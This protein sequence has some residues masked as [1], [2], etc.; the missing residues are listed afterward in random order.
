MTL[1]FDL[2]DIFASRPSLLVVASSTLRLALKIYYPTLAIN[3]D[4]AVITRP[5]SL[6]Q[7]TFETLSEHLRQSFSTG[8][9]LRWTTGQNTLIADPSSV[10]ALTLDIDI[11]QLAV[12]VDSVSLA[13]VTAFMQAM[14]EF[15]DRPCANA[16][17]PWQ[18]LS[19][20]LRQNSLSKT[21]R[22]QSSEQSG[23]QPPA[24]P[25]GAV[26][27]EVDPA[28][29]ERQAQVILNTQL[30]AIEGV[31]SQGLGDFDEIERYLEKV[32]DVSQV[33]VDDPSASRL[34][35]NRRFEQLPEWLRQASSGERLDYSRHVAALAVS[36]SRSKGKSFNDDLPPILKYA[37][38]VLQ[39]SLRED[40]PEAALTLDD[41]TVEIAKVVASAIPSGGQIIT[42]GSVEN[43]RMSVAAFALENL[44]SAPNGTLTL[45]VR[46]GGP[47]PDWLTPDYLKQLVFRVDIG[48]A[49][50]DLVRHYL[51]TD[52]VEVARR[53]AL[54]ADQL[55]IQLPL[56]ALEQKIRG[57]GNLTLA[58]YQHVCTVLGSPAAKG[59][60]SSSA[61]WPLAFVAS[62]GAPAD[63]VTNMFV[64]GAPDPEIGPFVLYRP[65]ASVP[66][67]EFTS[68][69]ELRTAIVKTGD[70]Q[71]DVLA[72]MSEHARQ[73]YA[74]GGF[75]Q[76]HI[77]R[78]GQGSDFAPLE[79]PPPAQLSVVKVQGDVFLA[80]FRAN[81]CALADLADSES[82]SN[83]ERRWARIKRG[84]WLALD[85]VMPFVSGPASS[86]LWLVQLM[87]NVDQVLLM[88]SRGSANFETWSALL[89]TLSLILLHQGFSAR[90][91]VSRRPVRVKSTLINAANGPD[92]AQVGGSGT[93]VSHS[94]PSEPAI[95]DFSWSSMNNRPTEGQLQALD[96]F[97]VLLEPVFTVASAEVGRVGLYHYSEQWYARVDNVVYQVSITDDGVFVVDPQD[98][99]Q[100]GPRLRYVNQVWALDVSLRLLGGAPKRSARLLALENAATLKRVTDRRAVLERRQHALYVRFMR[101]DDTFRTSPEQLPTDFISLAETDLNEIITIMQEKKLLDQALR[102]ADRTADKVVGKDLQGVSRR[103]VFFEGLL[104]DK[105]L[106]LARSELVQLQTVSLSTVMPG[107]VVSYLKLFSDLLKLQSI[108]VQWSGVREGFWQELRS[109]PKVGEAFWRDE[110]L[111]LQQ[112]NLYTHL[113]WRIN[114]L[115]SL[116]EL[117]FS[118]EDILSGQGAVEFKNLR[119][120][121]SL[122]AAFSS[123]SELEKPNDYTLAE[124]IDVLESALREYNRASLIAMS[125]HES[126]PD[127]VVM[128]YFTRFLQDL[129]WISEGAEKRLSD[130]IRESE[131]PPEQPV[132]YAPKIKQPRKRVFRT[133]A[134]R[135]LI[136]RIREGES[137]FP[138][139]VVDVTQAMSDT[140]IG[141]YHLHEDGDWVEVKV[142]HPARAVSSEPVVELTVL[143]RQANAG[144]ARVD[145]D[146]NNARRQAKR[147]NEPEDMQDI[148]VHKADKLN[149]LA[150]KL[151]AQGQAAGQNEGAATLLAAL[152]V[153]LRA[154]AARLVEEG[155]SIRIAMIKA[156]PPTA[157][158]VSYLYRQHEVNISRF[159][160]RKNMS[161]AKRNDFMQEYLIRDKD[162]R[163]L[164]WA[165]FHYASEDASAHDFTAAHLKVAEQRFMGYKA[166]V[167]AAK[168]SKDVVSIYRSTIGKDLAQRLFLGRATETAVDHD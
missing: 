53:Q 61:I 153:D 168:D 136:G 140:V 120:D 104:L 45:S 107:N 112:N 123:Q 49:Y 144:L 26:I 34:A 80:L 30:A 63:N 83:A 95:L 166:L 92:V 126:G 138:G 110:V 46:D 17:S 159:D 100:S 76:P 37:G 35:S 32:T 88:Q 154:G 128:E 86:T 84:G 2:I 132:E 115:W 119:T 163:V 167:K 24:V 44:S 89:L 97:K 103:I 98:A 68:L 137:D 157:A 129:S 102:P 58:G 9:T 106:K 65:F 124:Q 56:K 150:G 141:T 28:Q 113:E 94:T 165:H 90:I 152:V 25:A 161:G 81:A 8:K 10:V 21:V 62:P 101:W 105:V 74:N 78:F 18:Y 164:W 47:L 72:W 51:I 130:L 6:A 11:E 55:R 16:S 7:P 54:F 3:P 91:P 135:T 79:T 1:K 75:E 27:K 13:L 39:D 52:A 125:A 12:L 93:Q 20:A 121:K 14:V 147:A 139:E 57:E 41:V 111:E 149:D 43:V 42:V 108:G 109:V 85:T 31:L 70:L 19:E 60:V 66:L 114:R 146:I 40:H 156:Q 64:I 160:V 155:Q 118:E 145:L 148:L 87:S 134:Q 142:V 122:P 131:E 22:A 67:T 69:T 77:V 59:T 29:F 4:V 71:E 143:E 33:L 15:W 117:S 36:G 5:A 38:K 99:T 127:A 48:R 82:V 133:R 50:P 23:V 73:R 151:E 96:R 116:L 162:Q 158:R